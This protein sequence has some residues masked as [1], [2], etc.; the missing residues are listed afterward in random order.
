MVTGRCGGRDVVMSADMEVDTSH[1]GRYG[2][3]HVVME[4]GIEAGR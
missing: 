1:V 3:R 4:A 2:R